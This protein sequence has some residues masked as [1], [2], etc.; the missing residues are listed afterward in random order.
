MPFGID[1]KEI[2]QVVQN[3]AEIKAAQLRLEELM[4]QILARLSA[5]EARFPIS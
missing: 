1:P 2:A 3:I 5:L 4:K